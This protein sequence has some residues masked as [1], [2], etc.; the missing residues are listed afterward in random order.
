MF[1][2]IAYE[3]H[4]QSRN[5]AGY[6]YMKNEHFVHYN[7]EIKKI[8]H[9][10]AIEK[11]GEIIKLPFA[12]ELQDVPIGEALLNRVSQRDYKHPLSLK[13]LATILYYANGMKVVP[14]SEP[15]RYN[16]FTP[17]SGG[18]MSVDI[19]PIVLNMESVENGI[20]YYDYLN[21]QMVTV[22]TGSFHEWLD[23]HVFY[24]KEW[25]NASV[26]LVLTS[27]H[28]KLSKKYG[29]RAYRL[30]LL[31]VGLVAQNVYLTCSAMK[32]KVC[33]SAGFIDEELDEALQIDGYEVAS[34]L[35]TMIGK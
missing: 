4:E 10:R 6:K 31:D 3:Y 12:M 15:P 20:Y 7:D 33:A 34:F 16:K 35:T 8:T 29:P 17:T 24:Q 22:N 14:G 18:M 13:E 32:L 28:G 2:N 23:E 26:I 21:H 30:S 11:E 1:D 25:K 5:S 27:A 19:F 9:S